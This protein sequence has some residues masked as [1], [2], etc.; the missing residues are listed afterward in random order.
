VAERFNIK[1]N[2]TS[3]FVRSTLTDFEGNAIDLNA[4]TVQVVMATFGEN[5]E[6]VLNEPASNDQTDPDNETRGWVSYEWQP[7]DVPTLLP[8]AYW[9][10]WEVTFAGG[11]VETFPNDGHDELKVTKDLGGTTS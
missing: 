10:E 3:P 7:G 11:E 1:S 6:V 2:D 8:G 4:A 5:S 9:V